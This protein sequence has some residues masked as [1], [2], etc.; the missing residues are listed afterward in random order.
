M[1][2]LKDKQKINKFRLLSLFELEKFRHRPD[3]LILSPFVYLVLSS[4]FRRQMMT[5]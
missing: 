4:T 5:D 1:G 3:Q 2:S